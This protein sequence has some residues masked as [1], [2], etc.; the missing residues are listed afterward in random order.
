MKNTVTV[1]LRGGL[2]NQLFGWAAGY[3]LSRILNSQLILDCSFLRQNQFLLNNYDLEDYTV[4]E[5]TLNFRKLEHLLKYF[6]KNV[7]VEKSFNFDINLS[8]SK[9]PIILDGYFQSWKYFSN[10]TCAIREQLN[11]I[12]NPG[13]NY[14]DLKSKIETYKY[15]GIHVRRGDYINL[16]DYHGLTSKEY[17]SRAISKILDYDSELELIVFSDN[18]TLAQEVIDFEAKYIG[19]ENLISPVETLDLM[20]RTH[21]LI[22]SNSSFSWWAGWLRD[23]ENKKIIFP[24]PWFATKD[25]DTRDLLMPNW[26]TLGI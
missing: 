24:R 20:S 22:G 9:T 17:Y 14:L 12:V 5:S 6:R 7:F 2:G 4:N 13:Q 19:P 21:S 8:K 26:M 1:K 16:I 11:S 25:H 3:S 10:S 15:L 23:A 18:P